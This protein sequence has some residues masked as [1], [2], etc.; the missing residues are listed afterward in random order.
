MIP[1]KSS[2]LD[3]RA[4]CIF[5]RTFRILEFLSLWIT[6]LDWDFAKI[7]LRLVLIHFVG[8]F[9][10]KFCFRVGEVEVASPN[11]IE[12]LIQISSCPSSS[13]TM[14]NILFPVSLSL[15]NPPHSRQLLLC[16]NVVN[17]IQLE[18][19]PSTASSSLRSDCRIRSRANQGA[20]VVGWVPAPHR[21]LVFQV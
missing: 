3:F 10:A 2:S 15:L 16:L 6:G 5:L 20:G 8:F 18:S 1:S 7:F 19:S 21:W 13:G 9:E 4:S 17:C 11:T 14:A 12:K